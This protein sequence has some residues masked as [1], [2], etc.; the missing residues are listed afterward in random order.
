M[1][2]PKGPRRA[3]EPQRFGVADGMRGGSDFSAGSSP[4]AWKGQDDK[5]YFATYG[6]L[7]EIDPARFIAKRRTPPVV[8]EQVTVDR[9]TPVGPGEWIGAGGDLEFHYTALSFVFPEFLRFR[10]RL[11]DFD[12]DWV[13]AGNRRTAYYTNVPPGKYRFRVVA[14]NLGDAWNESGASFLLEARPHFY[15]TFWFVALCLAAASTAG[16][17]LYQL[18]VRKLRLNERRL[19]ERVEER[20]AALRQEIEV[21]KRAE[22]AAHTANLAKSEFL[23]NMSH[24][25]RTPMNGVL[26]M[27]ELADGYRDSRRSSASTWRWSRVGGTRC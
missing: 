17:A 15:Q 22:E 14:C 8:I 5:L 6:G 4:S 26:G 9:R 21:R 1:P 12:T 3:V 2:W 13:E 16:V 20:T 10:Y 24:E 23:A 25:I 18:R 7:L 19:A 11:E 27:T